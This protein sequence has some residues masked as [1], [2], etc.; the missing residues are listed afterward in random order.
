MKHKKIKKV[1]KKVTKK[2]VKPI[3]RVVKK[4][5]KKKKS[6]LKIKDAAVDV[7]LVD[8]V[9]EEVIVPEI[10]IARPAK[11]SGHPHDIEKI[12]DELEEERGSMDDY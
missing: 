10:V 7:D 6:N 3:K 9:A 5:I 11:K 12:L 2:P 1:V 4:I 8:V